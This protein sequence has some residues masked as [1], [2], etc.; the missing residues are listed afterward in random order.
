MTRG[1]RLVLVC[2]CLTVGGCVYFNTF[3]NAKQSYKEAEKMR[4]RANQEVATGGAV[5]KYNEAIKKASKV[6]QN[7]PKSKYADDATM[8]IG[9]SFYYVGDYARAREKFVE[10]AG[11][12][13]DS[14]LIPESR[15][16]LG[17]CEYYLG[18]PERARKILDGVRD[19]K[20]RRLADRA[21]FMLARIPF[22]EERYDEA[23][24]EL[25]AYIETKPD[26]EL[27]LRS[28]SMLAASFWELEQWDSARVAYA[29]LAKRADQLDL[30][31]EALY[32]RSEAAYEAGDFKK[33]LKEFRDL[34][35]KDKFYTRKGVLEYQVAM[36][37][38]SLGDTEEAIEIFRRLPDDYPNSE[39]A[40]R[41]LF[42]LGEIYETEGDSLGLAQDY[43]KKISRTWTG[44]PVFA[45]AAVQ[46]SSEIGQ[47]L[48]LQGKLSQADSTRFAESHF[49]LGE[50]YLRQ[51]MEPDSALE[52]FRLVADDFSESPYA[53]LA[54]LNMAEVV[55]TEEGDTA[56]AEQLWL[57]L[58]HRYPGTEAA[59]WARRRLG[60]PPPAD[61][62]QS[63]I[64]LLYGAEHMLLEQSDPD[65][66]LK[67]Y[68]L[69]I[70]LYPTSPHVPK[71]YFA[72]AWIMDQYFAR[73]DSSV[74][75]AYEYVAQRFPGTPYAEAAASQL[76]PS[77][78]T[79]RDIATEAPVRA[80]V[81]TSYADTAAQKVTIA[82]DQD[83][84]RTAPRP[85]VEGEYDYPVVPNYTWPQPVTVTFLIRIND[86]GEVGS[87]LELVGSSGYQEID[88]QAR[89]AMLKTRFDP[90]SLDPILTNMREQYKY[91][92]IIIPPGSNPADYRDILEDRW[93]PLDD[94]PFQ[95]PFD[96]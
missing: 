74:Y 77:T 90:F 49:L 61:I 89:I 31:F 83:T 15:Y 43:F 38:W 18:D 30:E 12:F 51:L 76:N 70:D 23:I 9:K 1:F 81:D 29:D 19:G 88:E 8:M 32:R 96:Q 26:P 54:M 5:A 14:K 68:D 78:R 46:R 37:L 66:A 11:V 33:G 4:L 7:H 52:E 53:P 59:M 36:G 2:T 3:F 67:L 22:E 75:Q 62:A 16:Y 69:L 50:L 86:Q 85:K 48:A 6:L 65:S 95:R 56:L 57:V 93:P 73:S 41:S 39:P 34:A 63:D 58:V 25:R 82:R 24:P 80:A 87:D 71:A 92:Y 64:L 27:R 44:D 13:R 79:A 45:A 20:D 40:A 35:K 60:M 10:L 72:R 42:A 94:D 17:M 28:D 91:E 84:V 21:R 47:R 55:I